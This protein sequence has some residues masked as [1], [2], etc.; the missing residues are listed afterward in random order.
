MSV[1]EFNVCIV[2]VSEKMCNI[3][4]FEIKLGNKLIYGNKSVDNGA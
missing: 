2:G 1:Q 4:L 3:Q